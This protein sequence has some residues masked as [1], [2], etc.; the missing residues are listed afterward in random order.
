MLNA[1]I[2]FISLKI[3][4]PCKWTFVKFMLTGRAYDLTAD[5]RE[6]ARTI[7]SS[8]IF[9]W[10]SRRDTHLTTYLITFSDYLLSLFYWVKS[11]F[12]GTR[13]RF[14]FWAHAFMN[15][16]DNEIVEAVAKGVQ[17]NYFDEAFDCDSVAALIPKNIPA[18]E[19]N[20]L[21]PLIAEELSK[22]LG[23]KYDTIFNIKEEEKVSCIEL[24]RVVLK[25][26]VHNYELKFPHFEN[27]IKQYKNVTPQMLYESP[28]FVCVWEKR[29]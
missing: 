15:F 13:P 29:R 7:M 25:H 1:I 17:K 10:V 18:S 22:Q 16:D 9:L 26:K 14:G 4:S 8:G 23:K 11:G 2:S 21:Q 6:H 3:I 19:W 5:D 12:K 28:D 27:T 20:D 24:V